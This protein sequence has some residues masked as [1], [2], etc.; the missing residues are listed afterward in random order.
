MNI[1]NP[2]SS[3]RRFIAWIFA[4]SVIYTVIGFLI[5]PPIVRLLAEKQMSRQLGRDVSIQKVKINPFAFSATIRGLQ[6][7]EK[8]GQP[9]VSLDAA[10]VNFKFWSIFERAWVVQEIS[11]T[12]PYLHVA[13][14]KDGAFN[15]Q[16]ILARLSNA[17]PTTNAAP[18]K[19]TAKPKP[20]A[21]VI[22]QI[23]IADAGLALENHQ[24]YVARVASTNAPVATENM[25]LVAQ[26]LA[27]N[28]M[29][30]QAVTNVFALLVAGTNQISG[31]LD[32][33]EVSNCAVHFE[34]WGNSRPAKLDLT[35]IMFGAK[36][37]S[38]VP[39]TNMTV[40]VSLQWNKSG[41]IKADATALLQPPTADLH[42]DLHQL[43]L[44]TLDPYLEPKLN[45]FILNSQVGFGGTVSL[46]SPPGQLPQVEFQGDM[47]LDGFHTVDGVM[48]ED[49]VKWSSIW[50]HGI[51]VS[52]NPES[53]S[54][55]K[56]VISDPYERII[57]ESNKTINVFN[58][59]HL[60]SPL[61]A[62]TNAVPAGA[63][64]EPVA[65]TNSIAGAAPV[66]PPFSIDEIVI[67]NETIIFT[68]RHMNPPVNLEVEQVS[69][70]ISNISLSHSADMNLHA[71]IEG[72]GSA[73]ITGTLNP[74]SQTLTNT[75]K[76]S[77]TNVDL[78]PTSPYSGMFAGYGIAEGKLNLDLQ[79]QIV[80]RKLDSKNIIVLDQF[81]FGEHV[82]SP[83]ATH[84]PVRL[85]I[86]LLKDRD[87]KI[88]L[89][90]PIQ[91]SLDDPKFRISKVVQ[92]V[93]MNILEKVATSP[94]SLLGAVFGGGGDELSYDEFTAG[95]ADL[96]PDDF[97]KLGVMTN[98]LYNRPGLQLQIS[99]SVDPVGD[100]DGLARVALDKQIRES[101]WMNLRKSDQA[102]N[103][104]DQIVLSPDDREKWIK[105]LYRQAV[106]D[107]KITPELL[108]ANTNLAL[109]AAD[110]LPKKELKGASLLMVT[111]K[112]NPV[113]YHTKLDPLPSPTEAVL[114]ATIP[115]SE[116]DLETLA[117]NRAKT[118]ELYLLQT[119]KVESSR[120]FLKQGAAQS[121]RSD[122]SRVYL[123]FQ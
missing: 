98:V 107:G 72:I 78:T 113:V 114:L 59:L 36:N 57:V 20:L 40:Q 22:E 89:D 58:A 32:D 54:L 61:L 71:V 31:T 106:A 30:L 44:G 120:L 91:G 75:I 110:V 66:L 123:Q 1:P 105:K 48:A 108:A 83:D 95:S 94:F 112:K 81:T 80:G 85:A 19:S 116:N 102:T 70:T 118:V 62:P 55:K 41:S 14:D 46:R 26:N 39:G 90:V 56:L 115:I 6:I 65:E 28:I 92:R 79:Y 86:A 24:P 3:R 52:L 23:R 35:G 50:Y 67:T 5:L 2:F 45:L 9:F 51:D 29:I 53:L 42:F 11:V 82:D 15:F 87:G 4:L 104:I 76:I 68:D 25:P 99:G 96:T 117:A 69:G 77:M 49:L 84:L 37:L 109:Y 33:L 47:L 100:R 111:A 64:K 12:K 74:F 63:A 119:G 10:Y 16:D 27:P 8:D 17:D 73:Q 88:V 34:D 21:V 103:S 7:N 121:L 18:A 38:N 60:P 93:I 43:D 13:R 101:I 122:G 97:K